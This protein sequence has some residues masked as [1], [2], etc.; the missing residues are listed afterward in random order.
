LIAGKYLGLASDAVVVDYELA[1]DLSVSVGDR[2]RITSSTGNTE[3]LSI[4][5]IYSRGQ[6]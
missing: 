3:S 1:K 6:R 4:S 5:G 2:I